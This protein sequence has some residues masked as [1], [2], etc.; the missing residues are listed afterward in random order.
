MESSDWWMLRMSGALIYHSSHAFCLAKE[1]KSDAPI[2]L[3]SWNAQRD[4]KAE[5]VEVAEGKIVF[6]SKHNSL[7][8]LE[9]SAGLRVGTE[10]YGWAL[11]KLYSQL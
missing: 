10:F 5:N 3:S 7:V 1:N 11:E 4:L 2:Y 6:H 8:E 9:N